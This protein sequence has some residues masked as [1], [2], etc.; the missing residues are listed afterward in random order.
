[1]GRRRCVARTRLAATA[2]PSYITDILK[3]SRR[4]LILHVEISR[5]ARKAEG[6]RAR[7]M[8]YVLDAQGRLTRVAR[9]RR[10]LGRA[11][12]RRERLHESV[13]TLGRWMLHRAAELDLQHQA[14]SDAQVATKL[15]KKMAAL[16]A[17]FRRRS[18]PL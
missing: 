3:R 6:N 16:C 14:C 9:E 1:M 8:L 7:W 2:T 15:Q 17:A 12:V 10:S 5:Q 4:S 18:P 11:L 13:D